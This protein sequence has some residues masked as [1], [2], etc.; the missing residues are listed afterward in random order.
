MSMTDVS[1]NWVLVKNSTLISNTYEAA[2]FFHTLRFHGKLLD[3]CRLQLRSQFRNLKLYA[4]FACSFPQKHMFP[5][6]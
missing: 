1:G 4:F 2:E 6:D 5:V 3:F